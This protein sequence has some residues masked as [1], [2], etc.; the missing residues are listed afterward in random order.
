LRQERNCSSS[1]RTISFWRIFRS[2]TPSCCIPS[3]CFFGVT[4][5][6]KSIF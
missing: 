5:V 2:R 3:H 1:S 6:K 4:N